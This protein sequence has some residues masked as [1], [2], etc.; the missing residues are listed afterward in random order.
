[1]GGYVESVIVGAGPY[2]LSLAAHLNAAKAEFRIFGEPMSFWE[3][4]MP[5]GMFL[6]SDVYSSDI[7]EPG[8]KFTIRRFLESRQPDRTDR[9]PISLASFVEYGREFQRIFVP[10]LESAK[11]ASI[12]RAGNTFRLQLTTGEVLHSAKVVLALGVGAFRYIPEQLAHLGRQYCTHSAQYGPIEELAG[13][14]VAVLGS[15]ASAIDLAAALFEHGIDTTLLCRRSSI[16]FQRPP[17]S[18]PPSFHRRI[19]VPDSGI[20]SGWTLKLCADAPSL[21]HLLP[22][23]LRLALLANTLGP[24]PGWFMRDRVL[25]RFPI[26]T[27]SVLRS[28]TVSNGEI[29]L[30]CSRPTGSEVTLS[31][32]HI[33]AATGFRVQLESLSLL[34][35]DI[36]SRLKMARNTPV[37]SAGFESSVP[38][39]YFI[40]MASAGSFGP[41]MRFV[42][43]SGFASRVL[44][45]ELV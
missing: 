36:R 41:V 22:T 21:V 12:D 34:S 40:G 33:V 30:R 8:G 43:G 9:D 20:G 6:K 1:M 18:T 45:K 24:A 2:G 7:P 42:Y 28:V 44:L 15:G 31:C 11:V 19:R 17:S 29:T 39:L 3:R 23:S 14:R 37:L 16:A 35:E 5:P 13:K 25:G 38:G 10:N 27:G 32:Q 26:L 4:N